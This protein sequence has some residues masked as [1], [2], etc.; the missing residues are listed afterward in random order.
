MVDQWLATQSDMVRCSPERDAFRCATRRFWFISRCV[1]PNR[2]VPNWVRKGCSMGC[3]LSPH[4][5][6]CVRAL[7]DGARTYIAR[8]FAPA[9]DHPAPARPQGNTQ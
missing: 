2:M 8:K 5:P 4:T 6:T 7:I 3:V 1:T 9:R